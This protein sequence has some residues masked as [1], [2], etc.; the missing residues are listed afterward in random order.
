MTSETEVHMYPILNGGSA[1]IKSANGSLAV[2]RIST[3]SPH[4]I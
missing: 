2:R 1:K 3:Q 4:R